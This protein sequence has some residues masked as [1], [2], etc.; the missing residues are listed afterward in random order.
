MPLSFDD[1]NS[2][3]LRTQKGTANGETTMKDN[4]NI[5]APEADLAW[6]KADDPEIYHL[7]LAL[8]G[9]LDALRW[10]RHRGDGLF[11]FVEALTGAKEAVDSLE[12][13]PAAKL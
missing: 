12:A 4:S 7:L 3:G 6:L 5:K 13:H 11:L 8:N 10:L 9:D 2:T 1:V